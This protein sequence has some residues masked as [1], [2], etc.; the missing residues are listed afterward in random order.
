MCD[1]TAVSPSPWADR[2]ARAVFWH[3]ESLGRNGKPQ[4]N[5]WTVLAAVVAEDFTKDVK[6]TTFEVLSLSTGNKCVGMDKMSTC[7]EV[8]NGNLPLP[9]GGYRIAVILGTM[10]SC[11]FAC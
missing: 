5:E 7:G 10:P 9:C 4:R 2:L 3:Y 6:E 1:A 8:L 11:R